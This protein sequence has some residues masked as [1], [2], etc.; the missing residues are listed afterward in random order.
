MD[1]QTV[2]HPYN[3]MLLSDIEGQTPDTCSNTTA[4]QKHV[5]EGSQAQK[6]VNSICF[7]F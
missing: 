3:G 7:Q 5:R 2:T 4:S 6:T 1:K